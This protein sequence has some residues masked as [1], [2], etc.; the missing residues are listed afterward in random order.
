MS[1]RSPWRVAVIDD[2]EDL[3]SLLRIFIDLDDRLEWVGEAEDGMAGLQLVGR[4][5]PDVV[6]LDVDMPRLNG[7]RALGALRASGAAS[8]VIIY[9]GRPLRPG[10]R[11]AAADAVAMK[12]DSISSVLD[13]AVSVCRDDAGSTSNRGLWT[14]GRRAL[15][16]ILGHRDN[17]EPAHRDVSCDQH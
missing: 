16:R 3:R 4:E 8:K 6:I 15:A 14:V 2:S 10:G 5:K 17:N 12:S 1:W 7:L 11:A 13:R 9:T